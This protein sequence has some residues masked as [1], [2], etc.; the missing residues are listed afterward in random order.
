MN[1]LPRIRE[2]VAATYYR[3]PGRVVADGAPLISSGV[4]D[5]FGLIDLSLF[6]EDEFG[7]R[8]DASELGAG[9]ADTAAEIARLVEVRR[10]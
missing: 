7:V 10:G 4:I 6:L 1:I 9:R 5:S 8:V 2:F 3:D